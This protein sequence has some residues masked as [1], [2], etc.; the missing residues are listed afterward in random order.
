VVAAEEVM[1]FSC[2]EARLSQAIVLCAAA[3]AK[4]SWLQSLKDIFKFLLEFL[5]VRESKA[6]LSD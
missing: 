2:P 3:I 6:L 4:N 5:I 1:N